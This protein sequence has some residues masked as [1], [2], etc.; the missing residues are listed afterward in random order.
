MDE[1]PP[2]PGQ[3]RL[4]GH[5]LRPT[6]STRRPSYRPALLIAEEESGCWSSIGLTDQP[7]HRTGEERVPVADWRAIG[8]HKPGYLWSAS[9]RTALA[10]SD[11]GR[12]LGQ[13]TPGL[14]ELLQTNAGL[15]DD[16]AAAMGAEWDRSGNV[17]PPDALTRARLDLES[18]LQAFDAAVAAIRHAFAAASVAIS[19]SADAPAE[20]E[21]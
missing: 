18:G 9:R 13:A 20:V 8:L 14:I 17:P 2:A 16:D 1:Q 6:D 15:S 5:N 10:P 19:Q 11:L 3:V 21:R 7:R 4:V 12:Q